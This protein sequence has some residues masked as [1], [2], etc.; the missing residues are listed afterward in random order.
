V[1][2]V[3]FVELCVHNASKGCDNG[4]TPLDLRSQVCPLH[5]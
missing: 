5:T 2:A 4:L 1:T 3:V